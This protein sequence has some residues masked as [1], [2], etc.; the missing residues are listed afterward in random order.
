MLKNYIIVALR[1][2]TKHR[3]YAVINILGLSIGITCSLLL[4]LYIKEELSYDN[5]HTKGENIYRIAARAIVQ[6]TEV[7]TPT[8]MAPMGPALKNDYPEIVDFVRLSNFGETLVTVG[9]VKFY[10][11]EIFAA[12]ASFFKIFSFELLDGDAKTC[13]K[14]PNDMVLTQTMASKLFGDEN[15]VGKTLTTET[16]GKAISRRI[17]GVMADPPNNSHITPSALISFSSIPADQVEFWGNLGVVTYV[18]LQEGTD[19]A[20]FGRNFPEFIEKYISQTFSQFNAEIEF[21]MQP[22]SDIY[23]Y[24]NLDNELSPLGEISYLYIFGAIAVFMLIVACI[25]YMNLA[26]ARSSNRAK[27]VGIR[28]AMGS[29][30][31]QIMWQFLSESLVVTLLA[32]TLSAILAFF[33]IPEFNAL[34]GKNI[35]QNFISDPVI[36]LSMLSIATLVGLL[37][38]SYPA[39]Y[40]SKFKAV[41]VL[42][43]KTKVKSGIGL[44]KTLVVVQFSISIVMI[45]STWIVFDQLTYLRN[46][47]LGF[48]KD[49]VIKVLLNGEDIR[50]KLPVLKNALLKNANVES[51]GSSRSTPGS[52]NYNMSAVSVEES[53]GEM[54]DKVFRNISIDSDFI[55]TLEIE[56]IEGRNFNSEMGA[57][58]SASVLV[59]EEMIKHMGW[60]EPLGKKFEIRIGIGLERRVAKVV[61]VVRNFHLRALQEPIEPVVIH[62]TNDNDNMLI[63]VNRDDISNT[64]IFIND[65]WDKVISNKPIQYNFVSQDFNE[66]YQADQKRGQV[67]AIFSI[68]TIVISCLGLFGL[69]SYSAEAKRKEIGIRKVVGASSAMIMMMISKDFL[70]LTGVSALISFPIAYFF[71]DRWLS[72]FA[73]HSEIKM[74][75]F[76]LSGLMVVVIT[77]ITVA[78]HALTTATSNPTSA[79]RDQ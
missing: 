36:G 40:L 35:D 41:E 44:R 68:L 5:F 19:P 4:L 79:L 63:R 50:S 30:R 25:N 51:V 31:S 75:T 47:D 1:N 23:L 67:F 60:D 78:Y 8:T 58:T 10:E 48:N 76:I 11:N 26:T 24:S 32:F 70:K 56:L 64:L 66:Q 20:D 37:G 42:A 7:K 43:R 13:L 45:I 18:L 59:N 39:M 77:L 53:D 62:N 17:T 2:I 57:D 61:G 3:V 28:K 15:P 49:Q 9:E 16:T 74:T 27:E 29:Y 65:T 34:S 52:D 38:G 69:A 54:V 33:I 14:E 6:D 72:G 55:P 46:K 21:F 22:L 12:D 71:M 73:F